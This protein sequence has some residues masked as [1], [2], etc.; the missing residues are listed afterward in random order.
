LII[1][2]KKGLEPLSSSYYFLL[3]YVL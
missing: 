3:F 1:V 2:N